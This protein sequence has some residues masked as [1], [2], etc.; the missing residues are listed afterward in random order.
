MYISTKLRAEEACVCVCV[1]MCMCVCV[2]VCVYQGTMISVKT[3]RG[4]KHNIGICECEYQSGA[5]IS[6]S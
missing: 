2:Y 3:C 5:H 4:L 6:H 1:C